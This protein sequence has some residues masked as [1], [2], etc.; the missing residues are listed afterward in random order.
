MNGFS[1]ELYVRQAVHHAEAVVAFNTELEAAYQI[2]DGLKGD[3]AAVRKEIAELKAD[4]GG[5]RDG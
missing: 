4:E 2:I 5:A 3:L 1:T